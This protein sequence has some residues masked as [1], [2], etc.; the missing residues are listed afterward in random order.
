[1]KP[2]IS[3]KKLD[4]EGTTTRKTILG[5]IVDS[6]TQTFEQRQRHRTTLHTG[7]EVHQHLVQESTY[8][9]TVLTPVHTG[10]TAIGATTPSALA[11][12][13]MRKQ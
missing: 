6:T 11:S 2:P 7:A 1:M 9:L 5:W 8:G 13:T 12:L 4:A 10:R 3:V